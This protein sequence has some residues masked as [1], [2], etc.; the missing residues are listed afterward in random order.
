MRGQKT[1]QASKTLG[2]TNGGR[3]FNIA[4]KFK[5]T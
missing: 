1:K 3:K 5:N 4:T 2:T